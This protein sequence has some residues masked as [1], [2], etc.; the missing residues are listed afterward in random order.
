MR[1]IAANMPDNL[2]DPG[3][4]QTV[5]L[6]AVE[7]SFNDTI[8]T[9][10]NDAETAQIS[11]CA[12]DPASSIV[13]QFTVSEPQYGQSP[14]SV[15]E[16]VIAETSGYTLSRYYSADD[17]T[18]ITY[19]SAYLTDPSD[20]LQGVAQITSEGS[21]VASLSNNTGAVI[22]NLG[23]GFQGAVTG[24]SIVVNEDGGGDSLNIQ[25]TGTGFDTI[26]LN[27]S[28]DYAGL[29]GGA[30]YVVNG[31]NG[32]VETWDGTNFQL[33]GNNDQVGTDASA[34]D[35]TAGSS[36]SLHGTGDTVTEGAGFNSVL[37]NNG[38]CTDTVQEN[39]ADS[40]TTAVDQVAGSNTI[41]N[42]NGT[43]DTAG[44]ITGAGY[45][46]NGSNGTIVALNGTAFNLDG[47]SDA[48]GLGSG[49][50]VG[51]LAGNGD[52]FNG[53]DDIIN[54]GADTGGLVLGTGQTVNEE[55]TGDVIDVENTGSSADTVNLNATGG[56][57]GL[58]GGGY[59]VGGTG[60]GNQVGT[61]DN[62]TVVMTASSDKIGTDWASDN[63]N[64]AA[65]TVVL[66]GGNDA[67]TSN[68]GDDVTVLS[69]GG[70][71]ISGN[72]ETIN[73]LSNVSASITGSDDNLSDAGTGAFFNVTGGS[74]TITLGTGN[75]IG[76]YGGGNVINATSGDDVV[77]S[78]TNGDY[79][80]ISAS[81]D[82]AGGSSV[83]GQGT[84]IYL[85]GNTQANLIGSGDSVDLG[86]GNTLWL[87]SG[88]GD[89]LTGSGDTINGVNNVSA[90]I[91]GSDDNLTDTGSGAFFNVDG[92]SN[93]V[94]LGTDDVVGASGGGNV[95]DAGGGDDVVVS[96][97]NGAFDIINASNDQVGGTS[98]GGQGTGIYLEN[99]A[100]ANVFGS[101]DYVDGNADDS[102]GV[103][104]GG[105]TVDN[106]QAGDFVVVGQ[107]G[108][109]YDAIYGSGD[110]TGSTS[111]NGQLP[112]GIALNDGAQAN[113][114]GSGNTVNLGTSDTLGLVAGTG[115][116]VSGSNDDI[117]ALS[118]VTATV[119]GSGNTVQD[120][121]TGA[122]FNFGGG[123]DTVVLGNDDY[124]GLVDG[125]N[126]NVGLGTGDT[127]DALSGVTANVTGTGDALEDLGTG[128]AFNIG[129]GND[130][131]MLGNDDYAGLV[132]GTNYNV[133]L[134]TGDTVDALGGVTAN[135][136]GTDDSL[137]DL[138]S[139][140]V[141]NVG[142]GGSDT[143]TLGSSDYLGLVDGSNY[144]VDLGSDDTV[145]ALA[146]VTSNVT[147]P[148]GTL[149]LDN[150]G[151][152]AGSTSGQDG[153]TSTS[154]LGS[155]DVVDFAPVDTPDV[156]LG[157]ANPI[158][159]NL[160]D[161]QV[162]SNEDLINPESFGAGDTT[163]TID[164]TS[165]ANSDDLS[166]PDSNGNPSSLGGDIGLIDT[167]TDFG[168]GIT[169]DD[170]DNGLSFG[171][172]IIYGENGFVGSVP[173]T[174][175]IAQYDLAH[176]YNDAAAAADVAFS[177]AEQS[178]A[179]SLATSA[180]TLGLEP[181][182]PSWA[183]D[184]ITWSFATG[185]STGPSPFSSAMGQPEQAV[186]ESAVQA[187]ANA[188]DL[189]LQEVANP[190]TA[191]F[192]VGWGDFDT[193][194]TGVIGYT[195]LT[196]ANGTLQSGGV[197]RLEDPNETALAAGTD[198]Q[199]A[200][201][202]SGATLY[203]VAL[204]EVGHALGL[205]DNSDPNSVMYFSLGAGNT[206]LDDTDRAAIQQLYG[207]VMPAAD[208]SLA[209][210]QQAADLAG[211]VAAA[212]GTQ[213]TQHTL[214]HA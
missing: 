36:G 93:T 196:G 107:T 174:N 179:G 63:G 48:V 85:E 119:V 162:T 190:T 136:T 94:L 170:G 191:D 130:T 214:A 167:T 84:G 210:G 92:N 134:G 8:T 101:N 1:N 26:N 183:D 25:N 99:G 137:E 206:T 88:A 156:T 19:D 211:L 198:G 140:A 138:G 131:V 49:D 166:F 29:L 56:Y 212:S 21:N 62:T 79:D 169:S 109:D 147:D 11:Q 65:S 152:N 72:G 178:A 111:D 89:T 115:N 96:N 37:Y 91:S 120:L 160:P 155:N 3:T 143:I 74:N 17:S 133:G 12:V 14:S 112:T 184:T 172:P 118:N 153:S 104:G 135:I 200:Y 95:I 201:A 27:A 30:G 151:G 98:A 161:Y 177:Q 75:V 43:G 146:G 139:G 69:G 68:E 113:L 32:T 7:W 154:S 186:V 185:P 5:Q 124:A 58:L 55:G 203:Q 197:V 61:W 42:L 38:P 208:I 173:A 187:W 117:N 86:T 82:Q 76:A 47:S 189:N 159:V 50:T 34:I 97:T 144:N 31:S 10:S 87:L 199:L 80:V 40:Y 45:T 164:D 182:Q 123:N 141:F 53:A 168:D 193:A 150:T 4:G 41:L 67:L 35:G 188:S 51:L 102:V 54:A 207:A 163:P 121:G 81:N 132:D 205:A 114:N 192:S 194:D 90:T 100:Q 202:G 9:A 22:I 28:G 181:A 129:G 110:I 46:V 176:G 116:F 6:R 78:N 73:G 171:D 33:T 70:Y 106:V 148:S 57:A 128:A 125:T 204:H 122:S 195:S 66:E 158:D 175:S 52:T 126:Y 60:S 213:P 127:V 15:V 77:V 20:T 149:A 71:S 108:G 44:L 23:S 142:G 165:F 13:G 24:S 145:D 39:G 2:Y 209:P 64:T 18:D 180:A 83:G 16:T 59:V 105:N 103:Y 157:G